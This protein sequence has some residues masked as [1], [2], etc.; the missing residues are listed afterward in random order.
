M[1]QLISRRHNSVCKRL[2]S[3]SVHKFIQFSLLTYLGQHL[4][5]QVEIGPQVTLDQLAHTGPPIPTTDARFHQGHLVHRGLAVI[6]SPLVGK[7]GQLHQGKDPDQK[8]GKDHC[9]VLD[10][11]VHKDLVQQ[12]TTPIRVH[13]ATKE[14]ET[15]AQDLVAAWTAHIVP[16]KNIQFI[17]ILQREEKQCKSPLN[18]AG[19]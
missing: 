16:C 11:E 3:S 9:L 17:V 2:A 13:T 1:F 6:S 14:V 12:A 7:S 5:V 4:G 15:T 8:L 18:F 10:K 19:V